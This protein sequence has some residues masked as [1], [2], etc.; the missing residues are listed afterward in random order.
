MGIRVALRHVT[1]YRYDRPVTLSPHTVRLRPAPHARTAIPAYSLTV[2]PQPHFLNWQQ[3]PY[4]NYLARLVFPKPTREFE[5]AVELHADLT[6]INPFDFFVEE[7]A[8][9]VPFVYAPTLQHELAPYLA[10]DPA[11]P[12]L[13]KLVAEHRPT[14]PVTTND[15][16]VNLN[17]SLAN[18]VKYTIR[19]EPGVQAPEETLTLGSGSCRDSGWLLVQLCRHLGIAARFVSGY[20]IQLVADEKPLEGPDGPSADFTDLHAWTEVYIPGA[21]WVGLDPTSGL[22]AA[23]GHIPLACTASP[24]S[25]APVDG[26]LGY[27]TDEANPDDD[28][29]Q[30]FTYEM[31]VTRIVEVPRVTKPYRPEEWQAIDRMGTRIDAELDE[32]DVRLTMGGEPTFVSIDDRDAEEWNTAALGPNKRRQACQLLH[33]LHDRW[34]PGGLLHFGQGKWYP[35]ESLPRWAFGCFWRPDGVPVW[36][37]PKLVADDAKPVGATAEDAKRFL[38]ALV[39]ALHL[40][41]DAGIPGFEDVWH[42]MLKERRLPVNVD[43]LD[44]KLDDPEERARLAKVFEAKLGAVVGFALPL[45]KGDA[46]WETSKWP[47]RSE[48]LFLLPGDSPMGLRLPL[49]ALEWEAKEKRQFTDETDPFAKRSPLPATPTFQPRQP[50]VNGVPK[51]VAEADPSLIRTTLCVEA[52]AG[53]LYVFLPPARKLEHYLE[54]VAAVEATAAALALPVRVEGYT[55]PSDPRI[56]HFSVTPDPGVI[57]V[58]VHPA[59]RWGDLTARTTEL[60]AEAKKVRLTT[61]KFLHDGRHTGTGGGNHFVLGGRTPADSPF[62]RRPDLLRSLVGFWHNHPS[63]SYLFSGLFVGPTS[64]HPRVDEARHDAVYE[65][66]LAASHLPKPP[67]HP[68]AWQVDR[69]FRH[70]LA[71]ATGN[72]H[73]T[74]FCIDKMFSPDSPSG[75]L[76]LVELRSFEMPPH[77]EMSLV[78]QLL[79]RTLVAWAWRK[80]YTRPLVRWGTELHDRFLLPHFVEADLRD[81]LDELNQAGYPFDPTWFVPHVEFRFPLVGQIATRNVTLE[82]RTAVEPWPV[83]GEE[84]G[85][86]GTTR[87]VD[88]SLE[89]LQ[90]KVTGMTD[91]RHVVTCNGRAVP[92][93][94]TGTNGEYVAGVRFR[95]WQPPS[96]LHPTIPSHAPLVFDVLD[97]WNDRSVGGC[98]YHVAHPGG[99]AHETMPVN[100]LE[101]EGR[102][103]SRFAPFGHTQGR[104]TP[105]RPEPNPDFPYTLDLRRIPPAPPAPPTAAVPEP[106]AAW[107]EA[108]SS[109][110]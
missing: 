74:E 86:G 103:I 73:R 8:E 88:S 28:L 13:S 35:G 39:E 96:C 83:L 66:E 7:S 93:H 36:S 23:E 87:F 62:L 94:P 54:L 6:P 18:R 59:A 109:T 97:L 75:R 14:K 110:T 60:Y 89:R 26:T 3:D 91:G 104:V 84:A 4:G 65:F 48:H 92:L 64:Q 85:G 37:D 53:T 25:A 22:L 99:R 95:A 80:P 31:S 63:F 102:R 90:V 41:A 1:T 33:R 10:A 24:Q 42:Y 68:P 30:E 81:A 43:P 40:P 78:Q 2:L 67:F 17:Q 79:L 45:R 58:N 101:A 108:V 69:A 82:L 51:P 19:L 50:S 76:G 98:V 46:G 47:L 21:G 11:G 5:V 57:E 44:S 16:L 61:E 105:P 71:D 27:A 12:L 70:L 56:C 77:A 38:A 34:A 52:R 20:L 106:R 15:F 55:P 49:A 9:Q 29:K 100:A 107:V 72:T 32:W